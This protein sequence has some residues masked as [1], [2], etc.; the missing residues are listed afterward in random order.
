M[1]SELL[2]NV[3]Y[4]PSAL[5]SDQKHNLPLK[6]DPFLY[7]TTRQQSRV[8]FAELHKHTLSLLNKKVTSISPQYKQ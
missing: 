4:S 3:Y 7:L 6:Y 8:Q 2:L 1:P 5:N